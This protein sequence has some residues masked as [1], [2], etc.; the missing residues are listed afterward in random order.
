[1][2]MKYM[3]M[4]NIK[5]CKDGK[6]EEKKFQKLLFFSPHIIIQLMIIASNPHQNFTISCILTKY[7]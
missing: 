2:D 3:D 1:M 6:E 4:K 7:I 5:N